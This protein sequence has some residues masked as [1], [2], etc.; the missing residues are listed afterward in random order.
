MTTVREVDHLFVF[1]QNCPRS[2]RMLHIVA[3]LPQ[4]RSG[5]QIGVPRFARKRPVQLEA[6]AGPSRT[7]V[8][9]NRMPL[10]PRSAGGIEQPCHQHRCANQHEFDHV[11]Y[12]IARDGRPQPDAAPG[13]AHCGRAR[14]RPGR[15][16]ARAFVAGDRSSARP[17]QRVL[18]LVLQRRRSI[19]AGEV[20]NSLADMETS[21]SVAPYI[22]MKTLGRAE[23]LG[24]LRRAR[25]PTCRRRAAARR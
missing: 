9:R 4:L 7:C 11:P 19:G 14:R 18:S 6:V 16:S 20:D 13:C 3:L 25:T 24:R 12:R 5:S 10:Q 23:Q 15:S 22:L 8:L 2:P 1:A 21:R 17:A